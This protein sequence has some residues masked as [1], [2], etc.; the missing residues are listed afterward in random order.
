[1]TRQHKRRREQ[2]V[3]VDSQPVLHEVQ[4]AGGDVVAC[5][6]AVV[7]GDVVRW[8]ESPGSQ[9]LPPARRYRLVA[10]ASP[11]QVHGHWLPARVVLDGARCRFVVTV[12]LVL[13]ETPAQ[14]ERELQR[15]RE[16]ADLRSLARP[17]TWSRLYVVEGTDRVMHAA[18]LTDRYTLRVTSVTVQ[19]L[20]SREGRRGQHALDASMLLAPKDLLRAALN[21]TQLHGVLR[22]AK[23]R[24][25]VGVLTVGKGAAPRPRQRSERT[26]HSRE[27]LAR[28]RDVHQAAPHGSKT[29]A[30]MQ[31]FGFSNR[32]A[33]DLVSK[34]QE[35]WRWGIR[36]ERSKQS[37]KKP[38]RGS[39]T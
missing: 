26:P 16:A 32:K 21:A 38:K 27:L 2:Y 23:R 18:H 17:A 36:H 19:P 34:S 5:R 15:V 13:H 11:P 20:P 24:S 4:L 12:D 37:H 28:V 29:Q 3:V 22:P 31:Q 1:M 35:V 39:K 25:D 7:A 8:V 14:H 33:T 30:V 9:H 6:T 10:A